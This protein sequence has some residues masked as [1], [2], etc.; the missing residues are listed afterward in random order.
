M[1]GTE[2]IYGGIDAGGTTFKC[3]LACSCQKIIAEQ[4]F[5]S[6]SPEETLANCIQFFADFKANGAGIQSLGI[7][8]F[9]PLD[10]DVT[11]P[12]YGLILPGPKSKWANIN[13]RKKFARALNVPVAID[14]DVNA[15]LLAERAWGNAKGRASAAYMTVGTGIGAGLMS[16]GVILGKPSHPEF[17]HIRVERHPKDVDFA[18]VCSIHGG[19]LEGLA[20]GPALW[21]RFGD[22]KD[23][24]DEHIAWD[25]L[26]DY[27]A[28]ACVALS[29]TLRCEVI[30]LGGG[31]MK[32]QHLFAKIRTQ[33]MRLIN[34]YLGQTKTDVAQLIIPPGLGSRAGAW[35]GIW[36][37]QNAEEKT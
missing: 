34:R 19:C 32:R 26:A 18:G 35:G 27:L 11:S 33:Y 21:A 4:A 1:D 36:L 31:V 5:P 29:L 2:K 14:T 24:P 23:L 37:A 13:L 10:V 8:S 22:P 15:A 20:S 6:T 25:I 7:A 9:G 3:L 17:G 12:D 16:N 30:I 28:Q